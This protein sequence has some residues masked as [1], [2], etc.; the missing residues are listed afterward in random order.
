MLARP[1][2]ARKMRPLACI[3][4]EVC[5]SLSRHLRCHPFPQF[6]G[7]SVCSLTLLSLIKA[8]DGL[9]LYHDHT[10]WNPTTETHSKQPRPQHTPQSAESLTPTQSAVASN[11]QQPELAPGSLRPR[12]CLWPPLPFPSPTACAA[13]G[14]SEKPKWSPQ[15]DMI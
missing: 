6:W 3:V 13:A 8:S 10:F 2:G 5:Q 7:F 1:S 15:S 12:P 14:T 11:L 4:D 9:S